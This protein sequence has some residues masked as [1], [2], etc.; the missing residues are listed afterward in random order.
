MKK[1]FIAL[2]FLVVSFAVLNPVFVHATACGSG[3]TCRASCGSLEMEDPESAEPC[4]TYDSPEVCCIPNIPCSI[5]GGE[6]KN[7][8]SAMEEP[9]GGATDCL[10]MAPMCCKP[11][12]TGGDSGGSGGGGAGETVSLDN[13]LDVEADPSAIIGLIIK[14]LLGVVGGLALVM[15]VYGGFQWLTSAGNTEKVKSGSMTM[16][17]SIIGLIIVLASYLLVDTFMNF[18][19]G[20]AR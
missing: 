17:W 12:G 11:L 9:V 15:T 18:L 2:I 4:G 14:S 5:L 6:C 1:I 16:L 13:P 8:C 7:S 20:A 10:V 3:G 19:S